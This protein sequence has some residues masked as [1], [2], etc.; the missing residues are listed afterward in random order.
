MTT[1]EITLIRQWAAGTRVGGPRGPR[2]HL[3]VIV[4]SPIEC[5]A[6]AEPAASVKPWGLRQRKNPRYADSQQGFT[7]EKDALLL[8]TAGLS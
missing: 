3:V 2:S 6:E 4:N 5:V 8:L 7:F 1:T